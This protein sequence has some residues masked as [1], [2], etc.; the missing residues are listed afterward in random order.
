MIVSS[1]TVRARMTR[2]RT[3]VHTSFCLALAGGVFLM[4]VGEAC[5]RVAVKAM[6]APEEIMD[7]SVTYMRIYFLGVIP[8]WSTIWARL[9]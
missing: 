8:T 2:I 4:I 5:A 6:G 7:Y 3:S 1:I 9:F